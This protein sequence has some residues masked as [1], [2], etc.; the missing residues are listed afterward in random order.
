MDGEIEITISLWYTLSHRCQ[1]IY[2]HV[3]CLLLVCM[4]QTFY[5][6]TDLHGAVVEVYVIVY[7]P[8]GGS[9]CP[10]AI[11]FVYP[12]TFDSNVVCGQHIYIF[13]SPIGELHC[14]ILMCATCEGGDI[15]V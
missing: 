4:E 14:F 15:Y 11:L 1:V 10:I 12:S 13:S 2:I 7:Q 9:T 6:I 5:Q 8:D 3:Q